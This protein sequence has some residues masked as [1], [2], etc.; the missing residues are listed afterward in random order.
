[1]RAGLILTSH[2]P[3]DSP[4]KA[5]QHL[6]LRGLKLTFTPSWQ[7]VSQEALWNKD[8]ACSLTSWRTQTH[9]GEQLQ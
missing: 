7:A 6:G 2:R 1:M 9:K 8:I 3:D 5:Q 4:M